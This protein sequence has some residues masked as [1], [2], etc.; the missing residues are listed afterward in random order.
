MPESDERIRRLATLIDEFVGEELDASTPC[1]SEMLLGLLAQADRL[2]AEAVR[3]VGPWEHSGEWELDG[4]VTP[5]AWLRSRAR[6][7]GGQ[8]S[9]LVRTARLCRDHEPT[10]KALRAGKVSTRRAHQIAR[11]V[12]DRRDAYLEHPELLLGPAESL[13]GD[14]FHVLVRRW[15]EIVDDQLARDDAD[16]QHEASHLHASVTLGGMVRLDGLLDPEGGATVLAALEAH[17]QPHS[18][19]DPSPARSAA[20]RRADA[21]VALAAASMHPGEGDETGSRPRVTL[22]VVMDL[23]TASGAAAGHPHRNPGLAGLDLTQIRNDLEGIG[24]IPRVTAHR[25]ACDCAVGRV[26]MRG[27]SELLDLGRR[28]RLITR[29]QRRALVRRDRHCSFPG[30]DR[31][32]RYCDAHHL[33]PW[34]HGGPTDL[35]NLVLLCRRHHVLCHEGGWQLERGPGGQITAIPPDRPDREPKTPRGPDDGT[36]TLAA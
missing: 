3:R 6:L 23:R 9:E 7:D 34:Q 4:A 18:P 30:C 31:Q 27:D 22:D 21:L 2:Q 20:Q 5:A 33:V 19:D 32:P 10:G 8:A 15:R 24:P 1:Q 28:S 26:I 17:D 14:Q 29:A 11:A 16:K 13:P 25:L 35:D 12:H 36:V